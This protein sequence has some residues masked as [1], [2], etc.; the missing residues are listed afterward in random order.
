MKTNVDTWRYAKHKTMSFHSLLLL[1]LLFVATTRGQI[2]D[3]AIIMPTTTRPGDL[4]TEYTSSVIRPT[5]FNSLTIPSTTAI[6]T[7]TSTPTTTDETRR[8]DSSI[9]GRVG[10]DPIS[11]INYIPPSKPTPSPTKHNSI[12]TSKPEPTTTINSQ[13]DEQIKTNTNTG[14]SDKKSDILFVFAVTIGSIGVLL[15]GILAVYNI[16]LRI[17]N[18]HQT[19]SQQL[20]QQQ[21][22]KIVENDP[23]VRFPVPNNASKSSVLVGG[24]NT[25]MFS[26]SSLG[27]KLALQCGQKT[28]VSQ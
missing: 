13:T 7:T 22:R 12:T 14:T 10:I 9:T 23:T 2:V 3:G 26:T 6:T 17:K 5:T 16:S 24:S 1:L 4:D 18:H 25:D 20:S 21:F 28:A 8:I 15:V 19:Q 27:S 11:L